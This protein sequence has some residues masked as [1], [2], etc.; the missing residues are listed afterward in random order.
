[1]AYSTV[2]QSA[3]TQVHTNIC[4]N[5]PYDIVC[6]DI[7]RI[8]QFIYYMFSISAEVLWRLYIY[9]YIYIYIIYI[10]LALW[11]FVLFYL[12]TQYPDILFFLQDIALRYGTYV[13]TII[14]VYIMCARARVCAYVY[15]PL[16]VSIPHNRPS[17]N[18]V[19]T[20]YVAWAIYVMCTRA[21]YVM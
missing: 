16:C 4:Q 8:C 11:R 14:I 17:P 15:V 18:L 1:M 19:G 12:L 7:M 3:H 20:S 5:K 6:L 2:Q 10:A 13:P 9:I 21:F